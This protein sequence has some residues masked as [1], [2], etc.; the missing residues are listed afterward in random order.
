[1]KYWLLPELLGRIERGEIECHYETTPVEITPT[2]AILERP[3][4]G[5][6]EV[7]ADFVLLL[8]GYVP[9]NRLLDAAGVELR[10]PSR[11]PAV[12]ERT[13]E[14]N[15]PG[16]YVAGTVAGGEQETYTI[17]IETCHIHAERIAAAV[18]GRPPPDAPAPRSRPES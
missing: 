3:D 14:T 17:F 16:L 12:D 10:G 9:D 4:G 6:F 7:P 2:A 11:S 18:T 1:V 13:M 8:T 5:T 15:V